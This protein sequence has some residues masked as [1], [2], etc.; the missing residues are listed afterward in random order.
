MN[1]K[2]KGRAVPGTADFIS[3]FGLPATSGRS[4]CAIYIIY[5]QNT[6]EHKTLDTLRHK[7]TRAHTLALSHDLSLS[8]SPTQATAEPETKR[9]EAAR[10]GNTARVGR[11]LRE[12]ADSS[13]LSLV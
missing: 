9:R 7:T 4:V 2:R 12:G 8:Y 3:D 11:F 10:E 5:R 6:S 13:T 1:V